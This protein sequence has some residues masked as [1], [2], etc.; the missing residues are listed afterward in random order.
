[1]GGC[2]DGTSDSL[3]NLLKIR[4]RAQ[5]QEMDNIGWQGDMHRYA[6]QAAFA[7]LGNEGQKKLGSARVVIV[8]MGALGSV[9]AEELARAGVGALRLIDRD[10]VDLTNLH[11]QF[12]YD[13]SDAENELPKALAAANRL[14]E[15]N[16]H[17]RLEPIAE[18]FNGAS[19]EDLAGNA[20]LLL[21]GTDNYEARFLINE[22]CHKK[23]I[24]WI[25]GGALGAQGATMNILWDEG[26]C[27]HCLM[28]EAP[29]PGGYA[30]CS[31]VGVLNMTTV[32]IASLV[33]AEAVKILIGSP[34][35]CR[36]YR[37][38]DL[39]G[40]MVE[41]ISVPRDP[42]CPVCGG[43]GGAYAYLGQQKGVGGASLCGRDAWQIMPEEKTA[44]DL[45]KLEKLLSFS[46]RVKANRFSLHFDNGMISLHIF[47]DG[48]AI[49]S[50]VKDENA[51][52]SAYA[53]YIGL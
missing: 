27:F 18:D 4:A 47:R 52:K 14:K 3:R 25:Y 38:V 43:S 16:S 36:T 20:D 11:R 37:S 23:G 35:V 42:D 44:L 21:D 32:L 22:V 15:I 9:M 1:V 50:G 24:P 31:A 33:S 30:T 45:T 53:E 17:I 46:G 6:R 34:D 19:G 29:A 10:Y 49:V 5:V 41:D 51:A 13:E 7:G 48:R 28:P 40:N 12:L 8:G 26:P 2:S 39:W